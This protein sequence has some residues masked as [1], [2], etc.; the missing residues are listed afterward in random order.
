M[1]KPTTTTNTTTSPVH[2]TTCQSN[3][4]SPDPDTC[5]LWCDCDCNNR[6]T[7]CNI[8][9]F[10]VHNCDCGC[11]ATA[12]WLR[13]EI[14][15]FIFMRGC[16]RLQPITAQ[17]SVWAWSTSGG[18]IA[19]CYFYAF[20]LIN[21]GNL[22]FADLFLFSCVDFVRYGTWITYEIDVSK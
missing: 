16:T 6:A 3:Y 22:L 4:P 12:M 21:K 8:V 5:W 1:L 13:T 19:Y 15:M 2:T 14:N 18:V 7:S 9:R 17:E 20:R 10:R 11:D